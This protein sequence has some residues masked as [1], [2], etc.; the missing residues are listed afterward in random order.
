M[1][2]TRPIIICPDCG[3]KAPHSSKGRCKPCAH[4]AWR[5]S[6]LEHVREYRARYCIEKKVAIAAYMAN[7]SK[8]HY[9]KNR[10]RVLATSRATYARNREAIRARQTRWDAEN[11]E[12]KR[13][14]WHRW[15]A[16]KRGA[17][18]GLTASQ[19][20]EIVLSFDERCAYCFVAGVPLTQDHMLPLSRGGR[21]DPLNVVPAC[22]SCNAR[23]HTRTPEEWL[24]A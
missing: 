14:A 20:Q 2:K 16:A 6:R 4:R 3:S 24:A 9:E 5:A 22:R 21:H 18:G 10:E 8:S 11:R 15:D 19:W 1:A 7:Y 12:S 17:G 23:K 13:A